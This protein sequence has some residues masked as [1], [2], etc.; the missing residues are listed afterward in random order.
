MVNQPAP[1][2]A[3]GGD[4]GTVV[5]LR[6]HTELRALV[7]E[8]QT[9]RG[10]ADSLSAQAH[11]AANQLHTVVS[12]IELGRADEAL[13]FATA[14]LAVAQQLTDAVVAAH[15]GARAGRARRRQGRARPPSA[16]WS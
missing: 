3:A 12:L 1:R 11:E 14:E 13:A 4:L 16:A 7:S 10:F 9:I 15:R 5:T 8:L 2:C 6:D